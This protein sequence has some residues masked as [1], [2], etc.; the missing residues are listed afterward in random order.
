MRN[1]WLLSASIL[2]ISMSCVGKQKFVALEVRHAQLQTEHTSL[3]E[4]LSQSHDQINQLESKVTAQRDD[5]IKQNAL[6]N[7]LLNEKIQLQ[8]TI[9]ELDKRINSVTSEAELAQQQL[10]EQLRTEIEALQVIEQKLQAIRELQQVQ[11]AKLEGLSTE[12]YDL[13]IKTGDDQ[14][15]MELD[16]EQLKIIL[17]QAFIYGTGLQVQTKAKGFLNDLCFELS[18]HPELQISVE[19]H[20]DNTKVKPTNKYADALELTSLRAAVMTR[21]LAQEGGLNGNQL[22]AVGKAGYFPRVSNETP[23]G[24]AFNNRIELVIEPNWK[25]LLSAIRAE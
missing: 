18:K 25:S 19:S 22:A 21:W 11:E 16:Q 6:T 15:E 14:A 9:R 4:N 2:A 23:A 20:T 12:L 10:N 7:E 17:Y 3:S 8:N 24:R 1:L 13:I 5:M